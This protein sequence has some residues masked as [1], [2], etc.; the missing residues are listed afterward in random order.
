[1]RAQELIENLERSGVVLAVEGNGL[2]YRAPVGALTQELRA[3]LVAQKKAVMDI[4]RTVDAEGQLA[5]NKIVLD[6]FHQTIR[7]AQNG[8]TL[9]IALEES[10]AAFERGELLQEQVEK[11][12]I[13]AAEKE[14]SLPE[15]LEGEDAVIWAHELFGT[16]P[17]DACQCCGQNHWWADRYGNKKC[18]VCHPGRCR[19]EP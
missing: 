10:L 9:E 16:Q 19:G 5:S 4:L 1:M 18:G 3:E 17:T 7:H 11:L 15:P 8:V 12:A 6:E 14:R 2:R 13:E